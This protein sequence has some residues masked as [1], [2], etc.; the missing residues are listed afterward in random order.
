MEL[1]GLILNLSR[2]HPLILVVIT[3]WSIGWKGLAL[4]HAARNNQR[5]WFAAILIL[6]TVGILDILYLKLW[7]VKRK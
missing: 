3:V 6:N 2:L 1:L 7:R 5:N 4:W